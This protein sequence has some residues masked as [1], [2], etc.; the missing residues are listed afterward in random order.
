[1]TTV[2]RNRWT[3]EDGRVDLRRDTPPPRP[4]EVAAR[5]AP[6]TADLTR[7]ALVVVDMQND[8]CTPGGW[9]DGIGV[10]VSPLAQAVTA[11]QQLVPAARAAGMPVVWVNWGNRLDRANLPPGVAHVYD[12][13]G[14]GVG[15]GSEMPNG[16]RVLTRDSWGAALV[17]GLVRE[18]GDIDVDKYRMSGFWD[19]PLESILRNLRVDTLFLAGVNS[20]QCVYA[21]L[22]DAACI[23]YDVVLVDGASATTSPAF[24]HDATLYNTRQCFGFSVESADLVSALAKETR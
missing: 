23:G 2:P 3:F 19:T 6:L 5:P 11:L 22:I 12:P 16:S 9:L 18:P 15:I 20:D 21:T 17:D 14:L 1:M 7:S 8:F 4:L 24:C 10:D 13:Q